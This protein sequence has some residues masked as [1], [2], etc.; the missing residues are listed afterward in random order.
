MKKGE[1]QCGWK[2]ALSKS[3]KGGLFSSIVTSDKIATPARRPKR[4]KPSEE[5]ISIDEDLKKR[6]LDFLKTRRK[7]ASDEGELFID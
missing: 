5:S 4:Y 6:R 2:S 7:D 1:F 3:G